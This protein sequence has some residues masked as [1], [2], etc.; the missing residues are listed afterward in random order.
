MWLTERQSARE[1]EEQLARAHALLT[2]SQKH[3]D[4]LLNALDAN[5]RA[6]TTL[7]GT[8]RRLIDAIDDRTNL[9][10]TQRERLAAGTAPA[11]GRLSA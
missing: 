7:E 8:Q 10:T 1:R 6:I 2:E 4:V 11:T 9:F 3:V 5:T